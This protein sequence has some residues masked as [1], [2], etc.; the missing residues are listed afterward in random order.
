MQNLSHWVT[1]WIDWNIA[2]NKNG[3]PNWAK[4]FVDSPIIVMPETDEFYKQPM[5]YAIGH[6]SKFVPRNSQ[7]I[8]STVFNDN[9]DVK[10]IAFL[11]PDQRIVIVFINGLIKQISILYFKKFCIASL[12]FK[13]NFYNNVLKY[14]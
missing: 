1:G 10:Q 3:A 13:L 4:N 11:T 7:R 2:L 9:E 12:T 14:I 8:Q 6:F 5:Y